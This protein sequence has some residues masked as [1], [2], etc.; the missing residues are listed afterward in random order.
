VTKYLTYRL[1]SGRTSWG[2]VKDDQVVDGPK[3][4]ANAGLP[5][6]DDMLGFVE[7]EP[8]VK[9]AAQHALASSSPDQLLADLEILAPISPPRDVFAVG[10]NY[11]DH[12]VEA[13]R[14]GQLSGQPARPVVFTKSLGSVVGPYDSIVLVP[15]LT[16]KLDYEVE[17]GVVLGRGGRFISREQA[18]SHIFGYTVINDISARDVQHERPGNQWF[19]GK[20]MDTFCPMGPWIVDAASVDHRGL[21]VFLSVNGDVRQHDNTRNLL[22]GV[23]DIIV[24][25]SRYLTLLPGDVIATGTPS[26]V[27]GAAEPPTFLAAGDVIEATVEGIGTLRNQVVSA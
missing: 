1:E 20:S 22:F 3:A 7:L 2:I 14:A 4:L 19:L 11:A 13:E 15:E 23:V 26:G 12:V 9:E 6:V 17:L 27:G 18:M 16:S 8:Q 25:L 10:A 24:E 21:D 5:V